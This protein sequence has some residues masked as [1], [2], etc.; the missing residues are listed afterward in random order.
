M[1]EVHVKGLSQLNQLLQQLPA[2]IERNVLRGSLRAGVKSIL[3]ALRNNTPKDTGALAAGYKLRTNSK[4]GAVWASIRA[5]G[6]HAYIAKWL[7]YGTAA[8]KIVAKNGGWLLFGGMFA[9]SI[10]H[11]GIQPRPFMAPTLYEHSQQAVVAAAHYMKQR[12]ATKHGL[13]TSD[14][15]IVAE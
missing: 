10:S 7:E 5:G 1:N 4:G 11:P 15:E 14:V 3:P 8:H 2:K 13:D 6:P 9:K 12:L